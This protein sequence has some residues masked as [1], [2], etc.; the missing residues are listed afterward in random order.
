MES[1]DF[2]S[3]DANKWSY[4]KKQSAS[5]TL[6]WAKKMC[7]DFKRECAGVTCKQ[8]FPPSACEPRTGDVYLKRSS[9]EDSWVKVCP[10]DD[11]HERRQL[12]N[13]GLLGGMSAMW[14]DKYTYV[15]QCGHAHP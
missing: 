4:F 11:S 2:K 8:T 13:Q 15:Y 10:G 1:F 14:T 3:H 9:Q 5:Y 7:T 6:E 12:L